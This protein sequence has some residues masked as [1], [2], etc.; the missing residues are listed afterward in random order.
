MTFIYFSRSASYSLYHPGPGSDLSSS[1]KTS[2]S[3]AIWTFQKDMAYVSGV[4]RT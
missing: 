4:R 3:G 2:A 1:E